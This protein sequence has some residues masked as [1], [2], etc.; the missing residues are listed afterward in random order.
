[1]VNKAFENMTLRQLVEVLKVLANPLRLKIIAYLSERPMYIS[2]IAKKLRIAPPIAFL[3]LSAL[4][5]AGIVESRYE[6]VTDNGRPR[7]RRYY[8]LRDFKIILTPEIIKK[9]F[10]RGK[11]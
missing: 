4:E 11:A 2:E 3:H 6:L 7:V 8:M 9:V 10:E 1:M 5:R